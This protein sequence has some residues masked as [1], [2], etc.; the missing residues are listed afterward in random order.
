[1]PQNCIE[2]TDLFL[3]NVSNLND[4]LHWFQADRAGIFV[5]Q[6]SG[7]VPQLGD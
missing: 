5:H 7:F 2:N 6:Q 3:T 1:M 4:C